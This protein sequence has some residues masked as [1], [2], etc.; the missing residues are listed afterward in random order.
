M[1]QQLFFSTLRITT[2]DGE[3]TGVG[4]GFIVIV[5]DDGGDIP[6]VVTNRHVVER[7]PSA[8]VSLIQRD[9]DEPKLGSV[10][11]MNLHDFDKAWTFHPEDDVDVAVMPFAPLVNKAE[12]DGFSPFFRGIPTSVFA[13]DEELSNLDAVEEVLFV[14][15][16]NG[17]FDGANQL[18]I[19]RRGTT[20]SPPEVDFNNRPQFL[21]DASVFP[22]S[23][24]SPVVIANQGS[25][26]SGDGI[27]IGTRFMLLGLIA[28]VAY[29]EDESGRIDFRTV[30]TQVGTRITTR[31][32]LDLG[33]VFKART[34][35]EATQ[36][37]MATHN[38]S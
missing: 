5:T 31:E 36:A 8:R 18:P 6:F 24:G 3:R 27:V 7:W 22:G 35:V 11:E 28:S 14:G 2:V 15:Y 17:M 38:G 34:I 23:S 9:G 13:L 32:M 19:V 4:T 26:A 25:Y 1:T 12:S 29:R 21:I 16:P 10:Y 20:A 30:P 37:F 33:F